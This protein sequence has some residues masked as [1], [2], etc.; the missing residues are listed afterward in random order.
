MDFL[1][2]DDCGSGDFAEA[3]D[4]SDGAVV[5]LAAADLFVVLVVAVLMTIVVFD[6][7]HIA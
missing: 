4:T 5:D 6:F 7:S 1:V 2:V 3:A